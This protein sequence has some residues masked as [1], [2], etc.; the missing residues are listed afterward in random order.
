MYIINA[1]PLD[2]ELRQKGREAFSFAVKPATAQRG[3]GQEA[4]EGLIL[5]IILNEC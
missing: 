4:A 5:I 3:G 1:F 2:Y